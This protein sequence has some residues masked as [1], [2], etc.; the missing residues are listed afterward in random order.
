MSHVIAQSV[1]QLL[2]D[3][4]KKACKQC[5]SRSMSKNSLV[6]YKKKLL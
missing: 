2:K 4:N 6:S 1:F 3:I 5:Q